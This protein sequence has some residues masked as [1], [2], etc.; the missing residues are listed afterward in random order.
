MSIV[1][2]VNHR[3]KSCGVHQFG[4]R[5]FFP[6]MKSLKHQCYY[7]DIEEG[8]EFDHWASQLQ[9]QIVVYNYYNQSTMP[10]LN[11]QKIASQRRRFRQLSVFHEVD[12]WHMG[13]DA[14]I[15]QDPTNTD[16]RYINISR[17]IPDY[18]PLK[19][20]C[21]IPIIS[22]F[23]FGLG[24]KGFTRIID[25]VKRDFDRAIIR[26][27]IPFAA[28]GDADGR[29]AGD[30]ARSCVDRLGDTP[31]IS[32]KI[33]HN[34]LDEND[35]L[36][37]L[38]MSTLNCFLYD[39]NYGRGISGTLDYALAAD[40]P[41]A[42]TKSWQFKHWWM[43]DESCLVDNRSLCDIIA[44]GTQ[45]L[46]FFRQKWGNKAVLADWEAIFDRFS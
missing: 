25:Y 34:L 31:N 14:L 46:E 6:A 10:W 39:E 15:H 17:P 33:T 5:L 23:G 9:P 3:E 40:K 2:F 29:G 35:L 18:R 30:W 20:E 42:I 8:H 37:W 28:F 4:E 22:S 44:Q 38:A 21:E 32:L 43:Q 24:G 13:F 19:W 27:N 36:D 45:N 12:I 1:L 11:P 26:F 41:I 16:E 7:I